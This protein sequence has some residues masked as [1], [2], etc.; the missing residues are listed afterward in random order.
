[1]EAARTNV[2]S[3]DLEDQRW[4]KMLFL[5]ALLHLAVF[6]SILFVPQPG[7]IRRIGGTIYEVSLVEMPVGSSSKAGVPVQAKTQKARRA[8]KKATRAKR[9]KVHAAKS[10]PVVIAKRTVKTR[11]KK[12]RKIETSPA[13]L[14]DRAVSRIERKVEA[15]KKDHVKQ[16]ISRLEARVRAEGGKE[17][18]KAGAG[19]GGATG[20]VMAWYKMEVE[21]RIKSNWSYPV[22]LTGD[23]AKK[24]LEAI[25]VLK[26][27]KGGRILKSWFKK[28]SANGIFDES[29]IKAI[30]RS[31]P[32]PPF[33]EAY[34][35]TFD[36]IEINFN[37]TDLKE[38]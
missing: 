13:S 38:Y 14:I 35:K 2:S 4:G 1:M 9:I 24:D 36:E 29:V 19:G 10:K 25:V 34:R 6:C 28:R 11:R 37:L 3:G 17:T 5:S 21:N 32:L 22:A 7:P 20:F 33:P 15:D 12:A 26:V 23:E 16:A 27:E 31:D 30:E 18:G 8:S